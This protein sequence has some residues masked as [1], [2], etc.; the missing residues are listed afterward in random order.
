M[1][2]SPLRVAA[3]LTIAAAVLTPAALSAQGESVRRPITVRE[4]LLAPSFG[5]YQL[6][7]DGRQVLFTRSDRD[8]TDWSATSHVHVHD[9]AS[10]RT[11]QLTNSDKGESN[12]RWL[13]DGRVL[14]TSNRDGKNA[15]W[16]ISTSGG[17][18]T[19][20]MED[21]SAP[22]GTPSPDLTR[23]VYTEATDRA[24]KKDWEARV[25]RKD[26]GYFWEHKLTY[27]HVWVYDI[28]SKKKT[29]L[30]VDEY[31]HQ[32]PQW[33]PD[34][35]WIAFTSTRNN[36]TVRDPGFTNNSDIWIVPADSGAIRRLTTDAGPDRSPTFSP[37]GRR[38]AYLSSDRVNSS[39]DQMDVKVI[40]F[41]GGTPVN[42]TA[43]YDY[44]VSDVE[45]SKD[46]RFIYFS[47]AE[48]LTQKLYKVPAAGGNPVEISFGDGFMVSNFGMTTDGTKWL[49]TGSTLDTP[50][51]VYLT[52]ADGRRPRRVLQEHDRIG[53]WQVAR[54]EAITWKG[55]DGLDIEGVLT[56]PVD[57]Q[58]GRRYP[59][60]LQVHGGP[61]GRYTAS[62]NAGAQVWAGRGFAVLQGNPRGSSGRTLAFSNA[63]VNDWGGKDFIDIMNG[64]D[65]VIALGVA[66]PDRMGIMGGSYGGFMTFW[67]V[68]QTDRFKAAIGHAGI[69][70]WY[71]FFGQTD[72]PNLLEYGFGGLPTHSKE[73]YERWSPVE[74]ADR[75]TTPLL[76]T[77]GENDLRVPISQAEQYF[78]TLKKLEKTVEFLRYPREGHGI[79]EP[80]HR[81]HLDTEQERWFARFI[82]GQSNRPVSNQPD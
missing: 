46:G 65:H 80:V 51:I 35:R 50:G 20:L 3:A 82:M 23:I 9:L 45:W 30:T 71:S 21:E 60:I 73:T 4:T 31:D 24:D 12:P 59:L 33:S 76:I 49:V 56:Y 52:E 37:D 69:S 44:S 2:R 72:I 47:A 13:P 66:D 79:G 41:E 32:G 15:L 10:G 11:L 62:F 34:G 19:K 1:L 8:T 53:D 74:Y 61:H 67:A 55:A 70:D 5:S 6:S 58:A 38:V 64:V 78:R 63:N 68:T 75:V 48:G 36:A 7:P 16:V 81:L 22:S 14:F 26:D 29:R 17:E 40:A 27:T 28:A 57:Y 25:K 77:H 43:D 42:L 18:A 54:A 39:A